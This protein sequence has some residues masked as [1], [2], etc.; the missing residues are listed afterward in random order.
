MVRSATGAL[1]AYAIYAECDAPVEM[2]VGASFAS[3]RPEV[4][5]VDD[6]GRLEARAIRSA[7]ITVTDMTYRTITDVTYQ[8]RL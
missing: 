8:R 1:K 4:V 7:A 6:R 3:S 5:S 2:V